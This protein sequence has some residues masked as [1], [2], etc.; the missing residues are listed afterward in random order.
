MYVKSAITCARSKYMS[1]SE[2]FSEP[3]DHTGKI[4]EILDLTAGVIFLVPGI[5]FSV[6]AEQGHT[7][8]QNEYR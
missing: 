2:R 8:V 3:V 4:D 7:H 1:T 5:F 6:T